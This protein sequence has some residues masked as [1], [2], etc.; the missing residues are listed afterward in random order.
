MIDID[1]I[2]INN[3]SVLHKSSRAIVDTGTTLLLLPQKL[4]VE[5]SKKYNAT[6]NG[7]GSF[8]ISELSFTFSLHLIHVADFLF[9]FLKKKKT[10]MKT[11]FNLSISK[12]EVRLLQSRRMHSFLKDILTTAQ[13]GLPMLI[14]FLMLFWEMTLLRTTT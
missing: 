5:I 13:L 3:S 7:D 2:K 6:D 10:V 11:S 4:A 8:K 9:F 14:R 12:L 1:D